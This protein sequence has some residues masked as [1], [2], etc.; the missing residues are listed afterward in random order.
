MTNFFETST[1]SGKAA[2]EARL[3]KEKREVEEF[4]RGERARRE[5]IQ[6]ERNENL[7]HNNALA[8]GAETV[9]DRTG[10]RE[11]FKA[12]ANQTGGFVVDSHSPQG[13][14]FT[15]FEDVSTQL[16]WVP[17]GSKDNRNVD[18]KVSYRPD[19]TVEVRGAQ[20]V[21]LSASQAKDAD[22]LAG[23]VE[24]AVKNPHQPDR[25]IPDLP[26]SPPPPMVY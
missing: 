20:T 8:Q 9:L 1:Q 10:L 2:E 14:N 6:R 5:A 3:A 22:T 12:T 21:V 16:A 25:S 13:E 23:V 26:P 24:S 17:K 18:V 11:A 15:E 4:D 19:G 7:A